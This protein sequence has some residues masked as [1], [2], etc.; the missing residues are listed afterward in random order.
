M[1]ECR[2]PIHQK[3]V[4][5]IKSAQDPLRE[6]LQDV[7]NDQG[8]INYVDSLAGLCEMGGWPDEESDPEYS[9]TD[10]IITGDVVVFTCEVFFDE[11]VYGGGCPDMPTIEHRSGEVRYEL[12][13]KTG[14]LSVKR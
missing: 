7:M 1:G 8:D 10:A 3:Y 14:T 4:D 11:K 9:I 5:Q 13:L 12:D 6:V 2:V